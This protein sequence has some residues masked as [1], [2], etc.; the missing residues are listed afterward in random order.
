MHL[1]TLETPPDNIDEFVAEILPDYLMLHGPAA[2]QNY[3]AQ[4]ALQLHAAIMNPT[5]RAYAAIDATRVI[6][7]FLVRSSPQRHT[8]FCPCAPC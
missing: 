6:A 7:L 2:A 3:G 1:C 4:S 5:I 8:L